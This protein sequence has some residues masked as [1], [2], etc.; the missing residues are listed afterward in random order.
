MGT[1]T[2]R[3]PTPEEEELAEKL[4]ALGTLEN[5]LGE[6]ELELFSLETDLQLFHRRY[7]RV[8]GVKYAELDRLEA[9]IAELRAR[10]AP[11]EIRAQEA[12]AARA[13]AQ[14][15]NSVLDEI[16]GTE[17]QARPS[18]PPELKRLYREVAKRVHPDLATTPEERALREKLMTAA[19]EAYAKGDAARLESILREWEHSPESVTGTGIQPD[20]VRVLRKIA[21][22]KRRLAEIDRRISDIKTDSLYKLS[23]RVKAAEDQGKDLL[24]DMANAVDAEIKLA[25]EKLRAVSSESRTRQS[26]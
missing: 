4:K 3:Q 6:K 9:E 13:K 5:E 19:N 25:S 16:A 21:Q 26:R 23:E 18:P 24:A 1:V 10:L 11:S 2:V 17:D 20:L 22:V 8:V 7:L 12:S 14:A 15:S